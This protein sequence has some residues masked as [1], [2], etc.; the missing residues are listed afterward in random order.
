MV[1]DKEIIRS[2]GLEADSNGQ[3]GPS[4]AKPAHG[5]PLVHIGQGLLRQLLDTLPL[6][7]AFVDRKGDVLLANPAATRIWGR[8]IES[9]EERYEKSNGFWHDTGTPIALDEWPSMRALNRGEAGLGEVIDIDAFDGSRKT[10]SSAAIPIRDHDRRIVGAVIVN[11]D[12]TERVRSED[13]LRKTQRLL[14][15]AAELG[16]TGSWEHDLVTGEI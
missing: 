9:G 15:E 8:V 4:L 6:G 5:G 16:H 11:E 3:E 1:E 13:A 7:V 2:V 12:V 10:I 14:V